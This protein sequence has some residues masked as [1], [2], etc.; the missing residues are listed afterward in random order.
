M[1][2][3]IYDEASEWIILHRTD[4]LDA[5]AKRRF[6]TWLRESPQHL[7]AYL[8]MS[9]IW[10]EVP[11]LNRDW[12]PSANEL[13]TRA[14]EDTNVVPLG[15]SRSSSSLSPLGESPAL[16]HV[17][18]EGA[19]SSRRMRGLA[20]AATLLLMV[21]T[22]A[23]WF[24]VQRGVYSTEIGEQRTLALTDGSTVE[25]NARTK[26]RVAYT[27]EARTIQ[28]LKGQALFKVAKDPL[29]PF[30]GGLG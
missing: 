28:L 9:T 13:I 1:N 10:E 23:T 18:G 7:K 26:I 5:D 25:L 19:E 16:P 14:R 24:Y 2:T 15:E 6:D 22:A 8:E 17:R 3:Q 30:Q 20:V 12:N 27:D 21:G 29:R 11:A 4:T